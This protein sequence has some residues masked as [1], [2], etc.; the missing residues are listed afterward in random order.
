MPQS[1]IFEYFV[2]LAIGYG[3]LVLLIATGFLIYKSKRLT[4][5]LVVKQSAGS[6]NPMIISMQATRLKSDYTGI[7]QLKK[8]MITN[9]KSSS[10]KVSFDSYSGIRTNANVGEI[11]PVISMT[12]TLYSSKR[13][14]FY[15]FTF[16]SFTISY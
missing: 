12:Q 3:S 1:I 16:S 14:G 6:L 5:R 8:Q 11:S 4:S 15:T 7:E 9:N 10:A 2:Y 13:Q